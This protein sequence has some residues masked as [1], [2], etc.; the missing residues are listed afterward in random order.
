MNQHEPLLYYSQGAC[1]MS[2][3]IALIESGLPHRVQRLIP[4]KG[5][6]KTPE[7]LR[8]N[9]L[10]RVPVLE[11]APGRYLTEVSAIMTWLDTQ[12]PML[13]RD[14]ELRVRA[15]EWMSML[16]TTAHPAFARV[17]RPE[18]HTTIEAAI[19][20]VRAN[21]R[22]TYAEVLAQADR[23]LAEPFALGDTFTAVDA[24]LFVFYVW[25]RY[26]QFDLNELSKLKAWG[27]RM[28]QRP[29]FLTAIEREGLMSAFS[30]AA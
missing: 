5:E 20:E 3:H 24:Y 18:R 16:G 25:A 14:P 10:G 15:Y 30:R 21:A 29:A 23:W 7:F 22:K 13:P 9:P 12:T 26:R 1:S 11:I 6:T 28:L 2:V 8:I 17:N 19:E 27:P 4:E